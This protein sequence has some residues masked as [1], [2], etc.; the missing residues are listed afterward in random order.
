MPTPLPPAVQPQ[1]E[2]VDEDPNSSDGG[3]LS[4]AAQRNNL[5]RIRDLTEV[6]VEVAAVADRSDERT[7]GSVKQAPA[8]VKVE[9]IAPARTKVDTAYR[10]DIDGL[11]AL[12]VGAVVVYHLDTEWLPGGFVGVDIFFVISGYVVAASLM[13]KASKTSGDYFGGF[14]ARRVKRLAPAL[15]LVVIVTAFLLA[16]LIPPQVPSLDEYAASTAP[17][18]PHFAHHLRMTLQAQL[19]PSHLPFPDRPV[20]SSAPSPDRY[21]TSGLFALIGGANV[22]YWIG[23]HE[24]MGLSGAS[25]GLNASALWNASDANGTWA[26]PPP[27]GYDNPW[28]DCTSYFCR[29]LA[30]EG[31]PECLQTAIA[32]DRAAYAQRTGS[33]IAAAWNH[34]THCNPFLHAWSLGVEEQ[35]ISRHLPSAPTISLHR[36]P[37]PMISHHL[38]RSPTISHDLP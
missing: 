1:A 21:Y 2:S 28:G 30:E 16:L 22:Y 24:D 12:A 36:P 11:R 33:A 10:P 35:V 31:A 23:V 38:P 27:A 19:P 5:D 26:P 25:A 20:P 15:S 18:A 7:T 29:R 32:L 3:G 17:T 37:S 6:A 9:K 34:D 4:P 13:R 8:P 14:F